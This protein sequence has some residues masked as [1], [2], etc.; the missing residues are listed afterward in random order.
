VNGATACTTIAEVIA[1]MEQ[2][3][4]ALPR[5]DGVAYFNRLYLQVT[6]AVQAATAGVTFAA[7]AFTERLDVVFAG[8]YFAAEQTLGTAESCPVAWRPLIE[9]RSADRAPIQFAIVGMNAHI[10]HDL[11]IAVVQTCEELG[12]APQDGSP[13]H[14]DYQSVNAILGA[15]EGKVAGWFETG[16]IA[17]IVD[18]VPKDVDNAL[19]LWSI[20]D[21]RDLAWCH[22]K[23]LWRLRHV[24]ALADAYCDAL[25]L[26]VE[27]SGRGVLL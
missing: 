21:A 13:E 9:E 18:V 19:A 14:A 8:L 6:E 15:V 3:D 10:N 1:R 26:L 2:I 23:Q 27:V 11:P 12:V 22:A 4:G 16:L 25:A 7:P 17:D 20:V 5:K 24:P